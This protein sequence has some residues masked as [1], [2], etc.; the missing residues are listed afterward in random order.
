MKLKLERKI[1]TDQSTIGELTIDGKHECVTLEDVVRDK[2]IKGQTAIPA[3]T[4][5]LVIAQSPRFKRLMPR[6]ENV[7]NFEGILIHWGNAAKD[8]DG[9]ILVGQT[10]STNFIGSS[11]K[12]FK[13]LFDKLQAAS[14]AGEKIS[15]EVG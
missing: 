5:N 13:A 10:S 9:C 7:P 3:G 12:T 14:K 8:T 6:L 4:Y 2:K 11:K 15:I 1:R